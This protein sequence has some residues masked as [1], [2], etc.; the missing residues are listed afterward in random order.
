LLGRAAGG[1]LRLHQYTPYQSGLDI[2][3]SSKAPGSNQN[4]NT[5][6]II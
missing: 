6:L 2:I 3:G 4:L 1:Q 5:Q